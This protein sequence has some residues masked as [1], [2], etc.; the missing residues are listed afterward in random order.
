MI[1]F[2]VTIAIIIF[3]TKTTTLI[4][5]DIQITPITD[6]VIV[7]HARDLTNMSVV[8]E[9]GGNI[10]AVR[11]DSGIIVTDS[12]ISPRAGRIARQLI[13]AFFPNVPIKYLVNTHHHSDHVQGNQYFQDASIIGHQNLERRVPYPPTLQITSD[14]ILK[15]GGKTFEIIFFGTAH[16]DNDLVVLD[17][18][19]RLLI[20][21]DLLCYRKCYIM[22]SQSNAKNWIALLDQLIDRRDEYDYVIPGHGGTVENIDALIE[23]RDYLKNLCYAVESAQQRHLT[24]DQA[25]KS[26]QLEQYKTYLMYDRINLDIEA[27]WKQIEQGGIFNEN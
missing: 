18:E 21:G 9:V 5:Q 25:K 24:L 12:F 15:L 16:T 8:R 2:K 17:R 27:Y 20:M 19:D 26:I 3:L 22:G 4:S 6:D 14:V 23:Q 10:T 11:T 7:L 13:E 1:N